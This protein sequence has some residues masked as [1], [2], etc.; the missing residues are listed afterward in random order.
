MNED[1]FE[2]IDTEDKAYW[3]GFL[4]ADGCVYKNNVYVSLCIRDIRHLQKFKQ[5]IG[6]SK[7]LYIIKP[8]HRT[9]NYTCTLQ[10][11]SEKMV[12]DLTE[13]GC[14]PRKSK[15]LKFPAKEV[16]PESL[17]GHF[18]RGYF[19][20]DGCLCLSHTNRR[21]RSKKPENK[22]VTFKRDVWFLTFVGT[23]EFLSGIQEFFGDYNKLVYKKGSEN[24]YCLKYGGRVKVQHFASLLYKD[25]T[26]W[27]DR[28]HHK[29]Q[30]LMEC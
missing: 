1:Y 30:Q 4:C 25:A 2:T 3:F 14:V 12:K 21:S 9:K 5:C 15:I 28:K 11:R 7:K 19:D 8:H 16:M 6:C 22:D 29:Y 23:C 27:L 18:I 20:G 10:I 26:I 13:K 17:L 24:T